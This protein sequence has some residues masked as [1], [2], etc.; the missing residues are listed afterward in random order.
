MASATESTA[1][2]VGAPVDILNPR[3]QNNGS[4][5]V[6]RGGSRGGKGGREL[7]QNIRG[8]NFQGSRRGRGGNR[9]DRAD[10][11]SNS[12]GHQISK[13]THQ[14]APPIPPPPG[15]GGGGSFGGRLTKDAEIEEGEVLTKEQ[16]R[17]EE[18]V[19]A[20][21][22]F[23]CASPVVHNS[24][25]PCNHRTCHICA[26]RLRAL[27]KTRACAHCRVSNFE[28]FLNITKLEL[29]DFLDRSQ[30]CYIY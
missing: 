22:C 5:G 14:P 16:D 19:E 10:S 9:G 18:G 11:S 26:L 28:T 27:Y 21:V 6:S 4:R 15:L 12:N 29:T 3:A 25:A 17:K 2:N 8:K 7:Q 1:T 13:S 24:V 23:I 30:V 20:E